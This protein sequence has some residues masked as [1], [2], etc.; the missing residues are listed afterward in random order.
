MLSESG[1]RTE[2]SGPLRDRS[3]VRLLEIYS[4]EVEDRFWPTAPTGSGR[5][6]GDIRIPP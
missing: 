4:V 5:P 6:V 3:N 2:L 1:S